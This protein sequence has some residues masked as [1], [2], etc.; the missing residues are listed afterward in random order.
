M[1]LQVSSSMNSLNHTYHCFITF[2]IKRIIITSF[3]SHEWSSSISERVITDTL[4]YI[5]SEIGQKSHTVIKFN[6][7]GLIIYCTPC[8]AHRAT[9]TTVFGALSCLCFIPIK[10]LNTP[11]IFLCKLPLM[12]FRDNLD[13]IWSLVSADLISFEQINLIDIFGDMEVPTTKGVLSEAMNRLIRPYLR[14][15]NIINQ[16]IDRKGFQERSL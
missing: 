1:I 2:G 4:F 15:T 5:I 16:A 3:K 8:T 11:Y 6:S 9:F 14:V 12:I 13:M 10:K 7:H